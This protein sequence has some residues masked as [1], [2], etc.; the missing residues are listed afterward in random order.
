MSDLSQLS[1]EE[2]ER[3][4]AGNDKIATSGA[5][6]EAKD[7]SAMGI[8]KDLTAMSDEEL[9]RIASQPTPKTDSLWNMGEFGKTVLTDYVVPVGEFVDAYT[10]AP[11]RQ[12]ISSFQ[13]GEGPVEAVKSFDQQFGANPNLAPT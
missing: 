7:Q 11:T 10:G 6:S 2:L 1:D 9:E 13:K 8:A 4:A 3:I 12:A 5:L